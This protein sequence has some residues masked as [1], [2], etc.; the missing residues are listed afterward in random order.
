MDREIVEHDW[1][2]AWMI[3]DDLVH[4]V[5]EFDAPPTL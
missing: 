2:W 3:G 4:E 5:E 1:I